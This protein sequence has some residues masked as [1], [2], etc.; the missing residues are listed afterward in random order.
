MPV[1]IYGDIHGQY[2]D[3]L[4]WLHLNGWPP[5]TRVCF[6]GDYV[7]RGRHSIEV[8]V[9]L[10]LLKIV[11]PHDVF[12]CRGNHEDPNINRVSEQEVSPA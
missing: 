7:D 9:L 1:Q 10:F 2:S 11:M 6:M 3:L 5:T 8:I 12:L 4:R